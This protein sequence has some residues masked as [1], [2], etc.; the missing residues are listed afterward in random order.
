MLHAPNN[1]T[2]DSPPALA[3]GPLKVM[4]DALLPIKARRMHV[5]AWTE[6][7]LEELNMSNRLLV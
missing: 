4:F 1:G 6:A 3:D 7:A 5:Q 2:N